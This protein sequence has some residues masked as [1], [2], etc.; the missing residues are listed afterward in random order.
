MKKIVIIGATSTIAEHC[1]R[2]WIKE[3]EIQLIL[4]GRNLE[5]LEA[6]TQDLQVREPDNHYEMMLTDF[7][8][9]HEINKVS[10]QICKVSVPDIILI[11]HGTLPD[12]IKCQENLLACSEAIDIN[13]RSPVLFAEAFAGHL[14][15]ANKGTIAIIG[16]VAGDRGRQSNYVYG[17]SK[18][19]IAC[20]FQGLQHRFYNRKVKIILIKPGPTATKMTA[21]TGL[22]LKLAN[23]TKVA[24]NIV[25]GISAGKAV[26]YTPKKWRI[27]MMIIRL[28][29]NY[30]FGKI[31][32]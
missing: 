24:L 16:S 28:I 1:A 21:Q 18:E 20:Y 4:V 30:I 23:P 14:D 6:V 27:L 2:E 7:Q 13:G 11:A 22:A 12:Q 31:R 19:M 3:K 5:K 29:P 8:N 15:R 9:P 25:N 10:D 32:I 17:A 26:I